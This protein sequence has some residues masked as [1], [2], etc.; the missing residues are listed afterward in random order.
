MGCF[1]GLYTIIRDE[2]GSASVGATHAAFVMEHTV[3]QLARAAGKDPVDYRR[4]LYAKAGANRHLVIREQDRD[5]AGG[6]HHGVTLR[7]R[8]LRLPRTLRSRLGPFIILPLRSRTYQA[9][10]GFRG[11]FRCERRR[12]E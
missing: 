10:Q 5:L 11:A 12:G 4:A 2:F 8:H 7:G 9:T 1:Y 6:G 3:D